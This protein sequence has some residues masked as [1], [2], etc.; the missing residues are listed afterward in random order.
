MI[1][2]LINSRIEEYDLLIIQKS[3]FNVCISTSYNSFNID[4]YLLYQKSK[5][6]R[7]CFY[8]NIKLNVNHWFVIFAFKDVC[9]FRIWIA[10]ER[11]I[12]VHNVY[13]ASF[14]SYAFITTLFVIETIKNQL[15]DDEEHVI[16]RNFNLHHLL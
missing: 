4:F 7:T 8:V 2:L 6:V 1:F 12:N 10:N 11:W 3:W 14:N 9:Y 15:N 13:N 16:L 5:N